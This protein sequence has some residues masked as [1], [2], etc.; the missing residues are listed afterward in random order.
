MGLTY[1]PDSIKFEH[2][3]KWFDT[4]EGRVV[5]KEWIYAKCRQP[6]ATYYIYSGLFKLWNDQDEVWVDTILEPDFGS[7]IKI[8]GKKIVELGTPD[9]LYGKKSGLSEKVGRCLMEDA[10]RRYKTAFGGA[11]ELQKAVTKNSIAAE[12]LPKV[13]TDAL[14]SSGVSLPA[15]K[16]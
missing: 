6:D 13:L 12:N 10:V 16:K 7:V 2:C 11:A 4:R 14:K 1:N 5:G 9:A 8:T 15:S 3:P